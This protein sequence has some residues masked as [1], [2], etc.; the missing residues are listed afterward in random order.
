MRVSIVQTPLTWENPEANRAMLEEKLWSLKGQTDLIVL[1]EMFT[2]G[3]SMNAQSLAEPMQLTT[4]RWMK[5]LAS[6][7][8]AALT[9]SYIVKENGLYY[10]RML[11]MQ[12]DGQYYTSDK[13]HLFRKAGETDSYTAGTERLLINWQDWNFLPLICYD[14]RFPVWSRNKWQGEQAQYD[15]LV[16]VANWPSARHMAW[17]TLLRARAIENLSYCI[18]VNRIGK[19]EKGLEYLGGSVVLNFKGEALTE[20]SSAETIQTISLEKAPLENFRRQFPFYLENDRFVI[21]E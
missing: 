19:D 5:Q 10:N 1:P 13:R 12:P 4:F 15:C 18:G 14:L 9:G 21:D 2:T 6:H 16:Y 11:W 3:F 17:E 8:G 7:T 20:A